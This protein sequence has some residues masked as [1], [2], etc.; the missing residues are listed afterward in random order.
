MLAKSYDPKNQTWLKSYFHEISKIPL[1]KKEEERELARR[2][3]AGDQEAFEKLIK[4][5]LRFVVKIAQ[6]YKNQGLPFEDLVNEGNLGLIE[7]ARRFDETRG[8]KFISFAVWWIRH[9]IKKALTEQGRIVRIPLNRLTD[10]GK[11]TQTYLKLE[12]QFTRSPNIEEVAEA[13]DLPPEKLSQALML[14]RFCVS[15]ESPQFD[16]ESLTLSETIENEFDESPDNDIETDSLK[17]KLT[18]VLDT[19]APLEAKIIRLSFGIDHDRAL[20][21][22]QIAKKLKLSPNKVRRVKER[23]LKRLQHSKRS[24]LLRELFRN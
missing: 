22:E 10:I 5:N 16:D 14:S 6:K 1:L 4:S 19:L 2:I 20:N 12:Q 13:M 8:F 24:H 23:A 3:H 21:L 9:A 15:L 11:I 18:E 7:A 17:D